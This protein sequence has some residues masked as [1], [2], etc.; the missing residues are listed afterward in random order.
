[1]PITL[2]LERRCRRDP[3]RN[4]QVTP[5]PHRQP[6]ALLLALGNPLMGDDGVA[7]ARRPRAPAA[8]QGGRRH[9]RISRRRVRA[10]RPPCRVQPGADHRRLHDGRRPSRDRTGVRT[11]RISRA[12]VSASPHYAGLPDVLALGGRARHPPAAE[13]RILGMEIENTGKI[14]EGLGPAAARSLP[15]FL[16]RA[17]AILDDWVTAG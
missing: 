6:Q 14:R 13:I 17:G 9:Q 1:M 5:W 8:V 4:Q 11:G 12:D 15:E 10:S 16:R 7:L 3:A 2:R